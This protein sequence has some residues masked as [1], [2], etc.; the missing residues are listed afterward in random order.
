MDAVLLGGRYQLGG[1]LGS[2]GMAEVRDGWDARLNRP[3]AI[4][5]LH[6][7]LRSRPDMQH[8]F[9]AE[10]RAAAA[11][12]H[13]NIGSVY[14]TGE[15]LG[16]PYIVMERLPG[17]TFADV[18]ARG[19]LPGTV[20]RSMLQ[21]VLAA[22][23][24]AH[25]A[26]I[27]HRDIKPGNILLTDSGDALK[28]ADFGIAKTVDTAPTRTGEILGTMA[29][30]SP[31]RVAG[32]AASAADDVYAVGVVGY[33]AL[34]GSAPFHHDNLG[35][36][37]RAIMTEQPPPLLALRPDAEPDLVHTIERAMARD[38]QHRF[39]SA[40][41]MLGAL[42]GPAVPSPRP[43]STKVLETPFPMEPASLVYVPP[44][45][46]RPSRRSVALAGGGAVLV[47]V[48]AMFVAAA[49]DSP[50]VPAPGTTAPA[51][52]TAPPPP[53]P[54]AS[55]LPPAPVPV[56]G[57]EPPGKKKSPGNRGNGRGNGK[58]DKPGK[59]PG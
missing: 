11:L 27:L 45:R 4:K 38:A 28:V 23:E 58:P 2:G 55:T 29:Y 7:G 51:V 9:H 56:M 42:S 49:Q 36:L 54:S 16:T 33:Q 18:L 52:S 32:E 13:P 44:P 41:D 30:L 34:A 19:A 50:S 39:R 37:A 14:D 6:P 20:V 10:A 47:A 22:L 24:V 43:P 59:G 57:E 46:R 8:R 1:V 48:T 40:H 17:S 35:A 53:A 31:Q 25:A 3:V 12:N 5:L 26:G 15:H 21:N